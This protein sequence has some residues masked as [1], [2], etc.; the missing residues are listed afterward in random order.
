M[1]A[2][3]F[4]VILFCLCCLTA[5]KIGPDKTGIYDNPCLHF[6]YESG[7]IVRGDTSKKEL[8]LVFTGDEFADGGEHILIVLKSNNI[9]GSFFF[10]GNFYR[11]PDYEKLIRSLLSDGHYLGAHSDMHLLYCDWNKRDSLLVTQEE[12]IHDLKNNY[13]VM[14]KFGISKKEALYFLP[15]YEWYNDSIS[16]WTKSLGIQLI[17]YTPGTLSHVD[18]TIPEMPNYMDSQVIYQSIINFESENSNGLN[19]FILLS[20]IGTAPERKDKF[21]YY[22]DIII[23]ELKIR[24]YQFKRIDELLSQ[25]FDQ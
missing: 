15:P 10:T 11:N 25:R 22:L 8:A 24:D 4:S 14:K 20:H 2:L 21:Y 7:A 9:Y 18:Y 23:S 1:R 16:A 19:G 12:F 6:G 13:K 5:C 17:N 3:L